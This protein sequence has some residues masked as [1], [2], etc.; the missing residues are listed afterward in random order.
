MRIVTDTH[1]HTL[2]SG[3]AYN[4]IKEMAQTAKENG[5]EILAL[6]EHA[7]NMPG[8]CHEFYF[9]NLRVVPRKQ[10]GIELLL[11][12]EANIMDENGTLDL[13]SHTL[14]QMDIVIAS[15]HGPCYG[16]SKSKEENTKAYIKAMENPYV[17]II[18]HPD[19]GRF[20]VD[21]EVL[22]KAAKEKGVLLEVNNSSLRPGGFR[23]D[24]RKNALEMLKYCKMYET[25]ITL[26]SDAHI[27]VDAGNFSYALEVLKEADF[28]KTLIAG[29]SVEKL[30]QCLRRK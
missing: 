18:G 30:K 17:N 21:Y 26:G 15:I 16:A 7:P 2:A 11:G 28:P 6:T 8:S 5:L 10:C 9:H 24:T 25:M 14:K 19:D 1:A 27:D 20:P 13:D 23:Q 12:T 22:A 4:T 29:T 3:H